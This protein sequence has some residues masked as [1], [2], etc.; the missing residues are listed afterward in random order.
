METNRAGLMRLQCRRELSQVEHLSI[1]TYEYLYC[2]TPLLH[3]ASGRLECNETF[4]CDVFRE[5]EQ[6]GLN[7]EREREQ[8]PENRCWQPSFCLGAKKVVY[9]H[10][11]VV[12]SARPS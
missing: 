7:M 6:V 2:Y 11:H 12:F 3:L 8:A 4:I 1:K 9:K 10:V 5:Y